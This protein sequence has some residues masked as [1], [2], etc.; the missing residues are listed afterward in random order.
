MPLRWI[1]CPVNHQ[2]QEIPACLTCAQNYQGQIDAEG[3][4]RMC[5]FNYPLLRAMTDESG[6][7]HAGISATNLT[8][9]LRKSAWERDRDYAIYPRE[10]MAATAGTAWHHYLE[11]YNEA[12]AICEVRLALRL[13]SGRIVTGQM[14]RYL[15]PLGLIEDYKR[16]GDG[17]IFSEP[18]AEYVQQLNIYRL[19]IERGSTVI[20]PP[21][22]PLYG[23]VVKGPVRSLMLLPSSHATEGARVEVPLLDL[24]DVERFLE[25][26]LD[27]L[28]EVRTP[29]KYSDPANEY[30]CQR[31]CPFAS[32]C[33]QTG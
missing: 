29:R 16:K 8:G 21:G 5:S 1:I 23:T 18:P 7:K 28:E 22:H 33:V 10:R 20:G 30:F 32:E 3:T 11:Q 27:A 6:R 13:P 19:M 4:R 24:E 17:K 26:S 2:L 14:D 31:F 25:R 15:P 12:G 9:C